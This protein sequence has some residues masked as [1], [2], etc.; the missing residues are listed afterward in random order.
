MHLIRLT[1]ANFDAFLASPQPADLLLLDARVV[2]VDQIEDLVAKVRT[3]YIGYA[4]A[5]F[6]QRFVLDRYG[7]F[8]ITHLWDD[9]QLEAR[10][11]FMFEDQ[12][13]TQGWSCAPDESAVINDDLPGTVIRQGRYEMYFEGDYD[14]NQWALHW[15]QPVDIWMKKTRVSPFRRLYTHGDFGLDFDW[16]TLEGDVTPIYVFNWIKDGAVLKTETITDRQARITVKP[17][18][19]LT[20]QLYL[21]GSGKIRIGKIWTYRDKA[22]LGHFLPGDMKTTTPDNEAIYSYHIPGKQ[23]KKLIVGFSGA[24]N[25]VPQYER[26]SMA[27]FGTPVLLFMDLRERSGVFHLGRGMNTSYEETLIAIIDE[28]LS[29]NGLTRKDLILTGWSMGSFSALYYGLKMQ[30]GHIIPCK[31]VVH[32]GKVTADT[33]LIYKNDGTMIDARQYLTGR[34]DAADTEHLDGLLD[35]IIVTTDTAQTNVHAFAMEND[36][37]DRSIA[38]FE[39]DLKPHVKQ[40]SLETHKGF[41]ADARKEMGY[42]ILNTLRTIIEGDDN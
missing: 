29:E 40:L 33:W 16:E 6:D 18:D 30:A 3:R 11:A 41:H 28:K 25:E 13:F 26:Q 37:L 31:P 2:S 5:T 34:T 23:P 10:L 4:H 14:V 20:V 38:W 1:T 22:G 42:F 19:R 17:G 36:E 9:P 35:D 27:K 7:H 39:Q 15:S 8:D 24:L 21:K 12:L 32:L